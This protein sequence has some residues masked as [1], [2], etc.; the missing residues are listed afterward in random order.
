MY[1]N[2]CRFAENFALVSV[3]DSKNICRLFSQIS[4]YV[5]KVGGV[6]LDNLRVCFCEER[7]TERFVPGGSVLCCAWSPVLASTARFSFF[8]AKLVSLHRFGKIPH[9]CT[10]RMV[11]AALP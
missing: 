10:W 1:E 8:V 11:A 6:V 7:G 4:V 5:Q 3:E 9:F 2:L